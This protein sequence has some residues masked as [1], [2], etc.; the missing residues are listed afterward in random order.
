MFLTKVMRLCCNSA[1]CPLGGAVA[2]RCDGPRCAGSSV[3][4]SEPPGST[5]VRSVIMWEERTYQRARWAGADAIMTADLS[6]V[7]KG[8]AG[9]RSAGRAQRPRPQRP[10]PQR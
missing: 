4:R 1:E 3:R 5:Q 6:A 9:S 7:F 8:A 2:V 10:R